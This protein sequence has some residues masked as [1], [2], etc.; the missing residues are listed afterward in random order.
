VLWFEEQVTEARESVARTE[1]SFLDMC[2][3]LVVDTTVED[4]KE[5]LLLLL[6]FLTDFSKE[7]TQASAGAKRSMKTNT[8]QAKIRMKRQEIRQM[9][10]K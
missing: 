7:A 10:M 2:R 4:S 6:S 8:L 9:A 5:I 1:Q 3:Y